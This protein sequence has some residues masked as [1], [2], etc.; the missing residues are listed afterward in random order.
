MYHLGTQTGVLEARKTCSSPSLYRSWPFAASGV[1]WKLDVVPWWLRARF[2][3]EPWWSPRS[4]HDFSLFRAYKYHHTQFDCSST[5]GTA[6]VEP[7]DP[8]CCSSDRYQVTPRH[9][10]PWQSPTQVLRWL[11][12]C[13]KA[14]ESCYYYLSTRKFSFLQEKRFE[15]RRNDSWELSSRNFFHWPCRCDRLSLTSVTAGTC[16]KWQMLGKHI[17]VFLIDWIHVHV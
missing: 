8:H 11:K 10:V 2:R 1:L 17:H 5:W 9:V 4:L 3:Q 13:Q 16:T 14:R 15:L 12:A 6:N 7:R